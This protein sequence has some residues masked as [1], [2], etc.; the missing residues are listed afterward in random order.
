MLDVD[1]SLQVV[2]VLFGLDVVFCVDSCVHR[3]V[4]GTLTGPK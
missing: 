3:Q 2:S 4:I 1:L